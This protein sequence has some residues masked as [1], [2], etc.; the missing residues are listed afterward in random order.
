[1]KELE[2]WP[3][4]WFG[5]WKEYGEDY[6]SF[7]SI[8]TFINNEINRN[9]PKFLLLD[10]LKNGHVVASTKQICFSKSFHISYR[11]RRNFYSN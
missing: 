5:F 3:Y 2:N 1:M 6:G 8:G 10:Y 9:Y 11:V 7:P 4:K